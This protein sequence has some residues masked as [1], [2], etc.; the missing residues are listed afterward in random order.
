MD[1]YRK[2]KN[3]VIPAV[4]ES[5][6]D[7]LPWQEEEPYQAVN[8]SLGEALPITL[9]K[10][11]TREIMTALRRI[12][13]EGIIHRDLKP[14]NILLDFQMNVKIGDF[15]N[16]IFES[17]EKQ[18][19]DFCHPQY[20]APELSLGNVKYSN[21]IDIWSAGVILFEMM[22]QKMPVPVFSHLSVLQEVVKLLGMPKQ[23]LLEKSFPE[24]NETQ[25][26]IINGITWYPAQDIQILI[27]H[28]S[29]AKEDVEQ[30]ADLLSKLLCFYP[31]QRISAKEA[32]SHPF[33][34]EEEE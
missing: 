16:A 15:G 13:S 12:H 24:F 33:L 23:Y 34:K 14:N 21:K 19:T 10:K 8:F 18:G 32:L 22:T 29:F 5:L 17:E 3:I 20:T 30:C 4:Q 9:V 25:I 2:R 26:K 11:I 1:M 7:Y 28:E 6:N 27:E 31:H